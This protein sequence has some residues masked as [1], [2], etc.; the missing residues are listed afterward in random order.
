MFDVVQK[1]SV[2]KRKKIRFRKNNSSFDGRK[3]LIWFGVL[4]LAAFLIWYFFYKNYYSNYNYIKED[5][6]Q[7][8]V[9]TAAN[10]VSSVS[11]SIILS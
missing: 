6:S 9:Y 7:Y 5:S 8:L 1:E 3:F 11:Y 4:L 10:L 2:Q